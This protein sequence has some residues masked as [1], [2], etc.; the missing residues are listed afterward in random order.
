MRWVFCLVTIQQI[1]SGEETFDISDYTPVYFTEYASPSPPSLF[2]W[3]DRGQNMKRGPPPFGYSYSILHFVYIQKWRAKKKEKNWQWGDGRKKIALSSPA[4]CASGTNWGK[5]PYEQLP[6]YWTNLRF[7]R[8]VEVPY[9]IYIY[10]VWQDVL[11]S[12]AHESKVWNTREST[13]SVLTGR[14][15]SFT[16]IPNCLSMDGQTERLADF[17][18]KISIKY[19]I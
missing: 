19:L 10:V 9:L 12:R 2:Q 17:W 14:N 1:N 5:T 8:S 6:H 15:A 3:R 4:L 13:L 11:P 18:I 16:T 7:L